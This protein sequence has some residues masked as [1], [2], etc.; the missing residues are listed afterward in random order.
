MIPTA[1][2]LSEAT[3]PIADL[4]PTLV[5]TINQAI[6]NAQSSYHTRAQITLPITDLPLVS[7]HL[8]T[9][10]YRLEGTTPSILNPSLDVHLHFSW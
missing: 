8:S 4:S 3:L 7:S 10:G 1:A 5:D 6:S 9:L 2:S